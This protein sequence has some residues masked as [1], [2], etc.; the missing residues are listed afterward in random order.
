MKI[1]TG[2]SRP[3]SLLPSQGEGKGEGRPCEGI[4]LFGSNPSP[5]SSPLQQGERRRDSF[6][7]PFVE[8]SHFAVLTQN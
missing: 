8:A 5:Q 2:Y 1:V 4:A 3:G 7:S 6:T